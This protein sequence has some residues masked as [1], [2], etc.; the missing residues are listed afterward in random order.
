MHEKYLAFE[1]IRSRSSGPESWRRPD[2]GNLLS[3]DL[4]VHLVAISSRDF[5]AF[6][7]FANAAD[8]A[9]SGD[10]AARAHLGYPVAHLIEAVLGEGTWTPDPEKWRLGIERGQF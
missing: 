7:A 2:E 1:Q 4:A 5:A 10:A 3:Y 8:R 9:D 6:R